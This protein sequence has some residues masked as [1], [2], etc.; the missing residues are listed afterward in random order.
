MVSKYATEIIG[1]RYA[2]VE[3]N[4]HLWSLEPEHKEP[5]RAIFA[6]G[7]IIIFT[8][9]NEVIVEGD[10]YGLF[11]GCQN[12]SDISALERWNVSK[13]QDFGAMFQNCFNDFLE[14]ESPD[15]SQ[16]R[17]ATVLQILLNG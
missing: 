16:G 4:I 1:I 14:Q 6:N 10:C 13:T 15:F 7:Y 2:T 17:N 12:L 5:L 11:A 3:P 8:D 9:E